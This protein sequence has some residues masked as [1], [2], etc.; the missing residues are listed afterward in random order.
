MTN[1]TTRGPT[2]A[3]FNSPE[4]RNRRDIA[5]DVWSAYRAVVQAAGYSPI[6]ARTAE[7]M[8]LCHYEYEGQGYDVPRNIGLLPIGT[9]L[10]SS[11]KSDEGKINT[12]SNRTSHFFTNAQPRTGYQLLT[13]Y[14][15]LEDKRSH[16]YVDHIVPVAEVVAEYWAAER[17]AIRKDK[18][19]KKQ[20][21]I[22]EALER[23]AAEGLELL[24]K[25]EAQLVD[26]NGEVYAYLSDAEARAYSAKNPNFEAQPKTARPKRRFNPQDDDRL[27]RKIRDF[28]AD[29]LDEYRERNGLPDANKYS[30]KAELAIRKEIESWR[31]TAPVREMG[32]V[33]RE[34]INHVSGIV[35]IGASEPAKTDAEKKEMF[36]KVVNT[37]PVSAFDCNTVDFS[38]FD[39]ADSDAAPK[40]RIEV[41][42]SVNFDTSL[43]AA[44]FHA[45][46]GFPVI[47]VC[48]FNP[49][50]G[51]CTADWHGEDCKGRVPLVKGDGTPGYPQ[52]SRD[53]EQIRKW[54]GRWPDAGVALRMDG[55]ILLDADAKD[56]GP[57][58]YRILADTFDIPETL[59]AI[60]QSGDGRHYVF[61]LPDGLPDAWL[62][63]WVRVGDKVELPGLDIKVDRGGLMF[64]E[65]T[66]GPKGVYRWID[67]TFPPATLPREVCDFLHKA[68]Y[69]ETPEEKAKAARRPAPVYVSPDARRFDHDQSKY[70]RDVPNGE[71]HRRLF[72]VGCS[73]RA[74]TRAGA[75]QIAEAMRYH[76][77]R[78]SDPLN[79]ER[80]I[81]DTAA[82]IERDY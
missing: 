49:A 18:Q 48:N 81:R 8:S 44:T 29:I 35:S 72:E 33:E 77:A 74:N 64:V 32:I 22:A 2:A 68:R 80:Y 6:E 59:S 51:R 11:G 58:S 20:A 42:G 25:C 56:G 57:E 65:P 46:D 17:A 62:K 7:A 14:K 5:R 19:P 76:A 82:R 50:T 39:A 9:K 78:F 79:D 69:V 3:Q 10:S 40:P 4:R 1:P 36:T 70:F 26:Q 31:K 37:F 24:P 15:A 23:L 52:A 34:E 12:A 53:L 71:R 75:A 60:T 73:I 63:S 41:A 13:R 38:S 55:H 16:E 21:R 61:K 47:P 45:R 67:P 28:V 27:T 30:V 54:Y 43:E 66:R